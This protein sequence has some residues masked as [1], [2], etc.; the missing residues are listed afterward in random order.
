MRRTT[1][2]LAVL[3]AGSSLLASTSLA[4]EQTGVQMAAQPAGQP[5]ETQVAAAPAAMSPASGTEV[6]VL[7]RAEMPRREM[8]GDP[9]GGDLTADIERLVMNDVLEAQLKG[10]VGTDT[11]RAAR[12]VYAQD[13]FQPVWSRAGAESLVDLSRG[14]VD[15]GLT[16]E[17][18]VGPDLAGRVKQRFDA[19]SREDRAW[20]DL[21]LTVAWLRIADAVS[22]GLND[23]G[24]AVASRPHRP[25]RAALP[26]ALRQAG[27]GDAAGALAPFDIDHAQYNGLKRVLQEYREIRER[28]GWYAIPSGELMRA[29]DSDERVPAVRARLQAEGYVVPWRMDKS[30]I[31]PDAARPDVGAVHAA[32]TGDAVDPA[33]VATLLSDPN[34]LD[35]PLVE[36]LKTF[37]SRHGLEPDGVVGPRTLE[38]LNESVDSKIDRIAETLSQWRRQGGL[39]E[40]Y[41]W[42]NIPSFTA[43][44]W[45]NGQREIRMKTIV[46]RPDRATPIFSDRIEYTV[47]NPKWYVP[48]SIA[49]RDKL[50]KLIEDSS[51]ADRNGFA[52]YERSTGL[53]VSSS[54]V[55]WNDPTS[56]NRYRL[57][58]NP[59]AE[60][61]LGELKIIFPNRHSVY[62]HGTPSESLFKRA[63]RAFSSGC[64]RLENPVGMANWLATHDTATTAEQIQAAVASGRNRHIRFG[65]QVPV[66][67]T[68]MTVTVGDD[69]VPK[70]WRDIY[71][72]DHDVRYVERYGPPEA[73]ATASVALD[74]VG[75]VPAD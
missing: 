18:V 60:N 59:S 74:T 56:V 25:S 53:R 43:E 41:V 9:A 31:R 5:A 48:V 24:E 46:G 2:Y 6:A 34:T 36:A 22:G 44:G 45:N 67:L 50:P 13:L 72:R 11:A 64:I 7:P 38:A 62:L 23:E 28:G 35:A 1:P 40:R 12:I 14:L 39:G 52:V 15:Y 69:G 58:Q 16:A 17:T 33:P 21:M 75:A 26:A 73:Q 57:V 32:S 61:A 68:Y 66:H 27:E 4:S 30:S 51:Y 8:L 29:G 65:V 71:K 47:A 54:A 10:D 20:A 55:N 3:L 37:Q 70:F 49:R 63:S 19:A 42:A